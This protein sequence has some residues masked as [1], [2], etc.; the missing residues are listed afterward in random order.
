MRKRYWIGMIAI[1]VLFGIYSYGSAA[2]TTP[3]VTS[4]KINK[5]AEKT[6]SSSVIL[7]N[8]VEGAAAEYRASESTTF[9]GAYWKPY[10]S[11]PKFTLSAGN[12]TKTVYFQVRDKL[13]RNSLTVRDTIV[14]STSTTS[15]QS[16]PSSRGASGASTRDKTDVRTMEPIK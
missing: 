5:G 15:T 14:L 16:V 7:N 8:T 9:V 6:T 12:G 2:I 1:A 3:R 10:S 11:T 4:F 13:K